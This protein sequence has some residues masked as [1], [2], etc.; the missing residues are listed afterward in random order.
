MKQAQR[1]VSPQD[2][3]ITMEA[4]QPLLNQEKL[5]N[6]RMTRIGRG[7]SSTD[8]II[9]GVVG[10]GIGITGS[11]AVMAGLVPGLESVAM[12]GP[13]LPFAVGALTSGLGAVTGS[14]VDLH[15]IAN[16]WRREG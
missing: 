3:T 9:G 2:M 11:L 10:A 5:H 15:T 12:L 16:I 1:M 6:E 4:L 13:S 8:T 7:T 14:F